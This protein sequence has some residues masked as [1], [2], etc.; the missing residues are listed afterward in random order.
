MEIF[1]QILG[2]IGTFLVVL[3][4]FLVSTKKIEA[5]SKTYQFLNLFGAIVVMKPEIKGRG[6][7]FGDL[8]ECLLWYRFTVLLESSLQRSV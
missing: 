8:L 1:S 2:W 6:I 4:Y 7:W 5:T 3:A